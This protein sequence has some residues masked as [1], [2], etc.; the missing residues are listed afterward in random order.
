MIELLNLDSAC[1][2]TL[3][4]AGRLDLVVS[5]CSPED[6]APQDQEVLGCSVCE[7]ADKILR[8]EHAD[9]QNI[10]E[11]SSTGLTR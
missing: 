4:S 2:H 11:S 10:F 8:D 3:T 6:D 1:V 5:C 9:P 7:D